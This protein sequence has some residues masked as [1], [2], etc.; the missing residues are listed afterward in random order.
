MNKTIK[1]G[2]EG[3][4]DEKKKLEEMPVE[5]MKDNLRESLETK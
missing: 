3:L 1:A 4:E 2:F 5:S